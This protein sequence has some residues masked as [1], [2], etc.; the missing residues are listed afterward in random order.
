MF[1]WSIQEKWIIHVKELFSFSRYHYFHIYKNH[2]LFYVV[3]NCS[4][5]KPLLGDA[6]SEF[7]KYISNFCYVIYFNIIQLQS[8]F[9]I[10]DYQYIISMDWWSRF[11]FLFIFLYL[12]WRCIWKILHKLLTFQCINPP[13]NKRNHTILVNKVSS[14]TMEFEE[15]NSRFK[16]YFN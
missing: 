2:R 11:L 4:N 12:L 1:M 16:T 3:V 10:M 15:S 13:P 8:L 9:L 6:C 14:H 7:H 5:N